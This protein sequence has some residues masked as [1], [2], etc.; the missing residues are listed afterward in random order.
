MSDIAGLCGIFQQR[1]TVDVITIA[2]KQYFSTLRQKIVKI[3]AFW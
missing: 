2:I 1:N 3:E